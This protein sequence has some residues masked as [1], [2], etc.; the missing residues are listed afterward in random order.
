LVLVQ[1]S[2]HE[3]LVTCGGSSPV[4]LAE[5]GKKVTRMAK[6]QTKKG[7]ARAVMD[8]VRAHATES[9]IDDVLGSLS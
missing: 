5:V 4:P 2:N 9:A 1:A 8:P 3:W 6:E 7:I